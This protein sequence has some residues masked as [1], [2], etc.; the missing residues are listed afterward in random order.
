MPAKIYPKFDIT[1]HDS[2][3]SI[4]RK[5]STINC[6]HKTQFA[7]SVFRACIHQYDALFIHLIRFNITH[8]STPQTQIFYE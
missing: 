2:S 4:S 5:S 6:S 1:V 8:H 3:L 7:L